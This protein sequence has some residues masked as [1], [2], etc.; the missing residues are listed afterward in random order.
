M[1]FNYINTIYIYIKQMYVNLYLNESKF[2][3][4]LTTVCMYMY[5]Y[6]SWWYMI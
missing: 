2:L 6:Y 4:N 3:F 5:V 1:I